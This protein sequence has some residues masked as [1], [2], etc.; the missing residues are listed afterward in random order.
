MQNYVYVAMYVYTNAHRKKL[1]VS[2]TL[3]ISSLNM[4]FGPYFK[5]PF[6]KE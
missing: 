3:F 2:L 6:R 5:N 1:Q 4:N